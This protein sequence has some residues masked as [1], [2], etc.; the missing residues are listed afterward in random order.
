MRTPVV[1]LWSLVVVT[2]LVIAPLSAQRADSTTALQFEVASIRVNRDPS[3]RPRLVRPILQKGG[4]VLM[5]NQTLRELIRT[6]YGVR[7]NEVIGGPGW[8]RSIGFDLEAR[9]TSD[10]SVETARVMLRTLL[11]ERFSLAVHREQR[12]LP[13]YVLTIA[14]GN[15]LGPQLKA[16]ETSCAPVTQ[17]KGLPPPPPPPRG[18]VES[19]PLMVDRGPLRCPSIFL[20]GLLS[21]RSVSMDVLA[22][23][24]A[25][26]V[27]RAVVNRTGLVGEFD[28][29]L[30][31]AP[32]LNALAGPDVATV[33]GLTTALQEQLGLKLEPTRGSVEVLVI[34][35]AA[36]P[37][38]N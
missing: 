6:A 3:D 15:R 21:A 34:D 37:T 28:L 10:M 27:G 38:E 5:T 8:S 20:P 16:A 25:E 7:E 13:I 24:L 26:P 35:R 36:M 14:T 18:I 29:D 12:D 1:K 17:P 19:V 30:S 33:P 11:A 23:E 31:Y 4:R 32:D 22:T 9:G 2:P